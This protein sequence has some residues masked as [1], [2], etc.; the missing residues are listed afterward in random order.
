MTT[1]ERNVKDPAYMMGSSEAEKR[2]LISQA[3]INA[4][5]ASSNTSASKRA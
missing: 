5:S 2:R 4:P 1:K 3:E